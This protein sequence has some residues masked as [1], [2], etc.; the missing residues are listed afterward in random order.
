[1]SQHPVEPELIISTRVKPK[2][3]IHGRHHKRSMEIKIIDN[4]PGIP[5]HLIDTLFFPLVSGSPDGTG[6]GLS[7]S[8][9]LIHQH[10][11]RIDCDSWPGHTEFTLLIPFKEQNP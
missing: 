8:Q 3:T 11:G 9:T 5:A 10:Q 6:L 7:I 2:Q 4:G 1:M